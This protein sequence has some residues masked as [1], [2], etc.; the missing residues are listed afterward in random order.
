MKSPM[1]PEM[2]LLHKYPEES[3]TSRNDRYTIYKYPEESMPPELTGT[4]MS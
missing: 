2:Q 4:Q 1:P 3:H